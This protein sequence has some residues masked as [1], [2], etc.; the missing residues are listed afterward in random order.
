MVVEYP[1]VCNLS[2]QTVCGSFER[3]GTQADT[4][5]SRLVSFTERL[6]TRRKAKKRYIIQKN[7]RKSSIREW[8][9]AIVWAVVFVFLINQFVFQLYQIP[10][11]SM[12]DT[13]LIKD[14]LF[15]DKVVFGP[16]IYPGGPKLFQGNDPL[17]ND[18]IIFENPEY[19][20]RGPFFD[21]I[22]RIVYM[23]TLS[24]VNLDTDE[25]GNPRSQLYVK[26][27]IGYGEDQL[28]FQKGEVYIQPAGFSQPVPEQ[29]FRR[30]AGLNQV[31]SRLFNESDYDGFTA[32]ARVIAYRHVGITPSSELLTRAQRVVDRNLY[33][34]YY[35]QREYYQTLHK[36]SPHD[37]S[38]HS[39]LARYTN[40][41]YI[42]EGYVLP[43]GDN[44]DNSADG[45]YFGTVSNEEMLGKAVFRFWPLS[46]IGLLK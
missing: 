29:E 23:I 18:I 28:T 3:M 5:S 36:I 30:E 46:R 10:S 9:E 24:L 21:I 17:R 42:P 22:N 40:G 13:L 25:Q 2:M 1:V 15:V 20:S 14:R 34:F 11:P 45:R 38:V 31:V 12:E 26:R 39:E 37:A 44:R 19:E 43:L 33:D 35:I 32:Y 7:K 41:Y 8:L 4:W 16:Q 27:A 6:L